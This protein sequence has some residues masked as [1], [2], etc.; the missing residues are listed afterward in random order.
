MP[1][2]YI[3]PV[4]SVAELHSLGSHK[5]FVATAIVESFPTDLPLT[6]NI[7]EPNKKISIFKEILETLNSAPSKFF[8]RNNG[9][10]ISA[11]K[12]K[13]HKTSS[14]SEIHVEC[15]EDSE[16]YTSFG[17][18]DGGHTIAAISTAKTQKIDLTKALVKV[19]ITCGLP[20]DEVAV[21]AL[22]ANTTSP[23]DNRSKVNARGG[24]DFVKRFIDKLEDEL[25]IKYKVA[26]YQN[27]GGVPKDPR[28]SVQHLCK[29]L[30]CL[31]RVKYDYSSTGRSQHP[32]SLTVPQFLSPKETERLQKLLPLLP[33]GLWIERE[34]YKL[35]EKYITN[36]AV[37][38]NF[39]L[40]SISLSGNS[41]L[42]DGSAFGFKTPSVLSLP[43]IA[44]FRVFLD[45]DYQWTLPFDEFKT[46]VLNKL[47]ERLR[48]E[49]KAEMGKGNN[50]IGTT[51][52]RQ[53][54]F[55]SSLCNTSLEEKNRILEGM[56][57]D[58]R[59]QTVPP[60]SHSKGVG[61]RV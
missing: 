58:I 51:L 13:I 3:I 42:A 1:K 60:G 18:Y 14:G 22:T 57:R 31:D 7:R 36:P 56:T 32:S 45:N 37:K 54:N 28:C 38:G 24:Y 4:K 12:V 33:Y 27:Q 25:D 6:P 53:V 44:S 46:S 19:E 50:A 21:N 39:N 47:W 8:D 41:L 5:F 40:A 59:T 11:Y 2:T 48:S 15:L 20:E 35:I 23:I 49:L 43:I 10:K 9:I 55:W 16:G 17:V 29:I 34:L 30:I 26:Y 61:G 52:Y